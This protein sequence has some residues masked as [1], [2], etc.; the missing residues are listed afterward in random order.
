MKRQQR[1]ER[2]GEKWGKKKRGQDEKRSEKQREDESKSITTQQYKLI[3]Y[4]S[5]ISKTSY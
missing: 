4:Q 5:S 1:K 3:Q 2:Y